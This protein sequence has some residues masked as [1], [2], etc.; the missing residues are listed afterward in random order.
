MEA[1]FTQRYDGRDL[2][3]GRLLTDAGPYKR[4]AVSYRGDGERITGIMNIPDGKGPFPVVVLNHGYIDP[5]TYW[6]GQ[7]MP[8]EQ[9]VLARRGFAVL[10]VDYRNHAGSSKDPDVDHELRLPYVVDTVNAV[11]A[12]K[13]ARGAAFA[14]LD[15][16]NVGW[17]GRSMGGGV[18]LRAL[19]AQPGLVEAGA[20]WASVSSLEAENW[21]RWFEKSPERRGTNRRIE[22]TYGLPDDSPAFWRRASARPFFDRITEPVLVQHGGSDRTCPPRWSRATVDA[23]EEADVEVRSNVYPGA[24]HT[25]EG[26]TFSTAMERTVDF[27][28]DHLR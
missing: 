28:D 20:V 11:K 19:A 8:R 21:E 12:V 18:T 2:T 3:R 4:Y 17:F 23:L 27:F 14:S 13:A 24:D 10:H 9:D 16:E 5:A 25:F 22:R 1:L 15:R 6:S 26:R 7:G